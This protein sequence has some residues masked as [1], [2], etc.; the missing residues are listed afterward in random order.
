MNA[1][2]RSLTVVAGL[3]PPFRSQVQVAT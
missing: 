2:P 1:M 3:T